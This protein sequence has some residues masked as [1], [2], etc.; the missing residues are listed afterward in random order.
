MTEPYSLDNESSDG[1]SSIE[2]SPRQ[3][4]HQAQQQQQQ[5]LLSPR[6][7]SSVGDSSD[8]EERSLG[9]WH[10]QQQQQQEVQHRAGQPTLHHHPKGGG[11]TADITLDGCVAAAA[12]GRQQGKPA[13]IAAAAAAAAAATAAAA[14]GSLPIEVDVK[15]GEECGE[16]GELR[17]ATAHFI[18]SHVMSPD[19][20]GSRRTQQQHHQQ[21]SRRQLQLPQEPSLP[22]TISMLGAEQSGSLS[23]PAT[24]PAGTAPDWDSQHS[25]TSLAAAAAAGAPQPRSV[26]PRPS[27]C[28]RHQQQGLRGPA[29]G[30]AAAGAPC[31]GGRSAAAAAVAAARAGVLDEEGDHWCSNA[32]ILAKQQAKELQQQNDALVRVLERE[33]QQHTETRQQVSHP[34]A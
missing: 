22:S 21:H 7:S 4:P 17:G 8:E 34:T 16:E 9:A 31:G 15:C 27:L 19:A 14:D 2:G 20:A 10:R 33:R 25:S 29:A 6:D 26:K 5:S 13:V 24:S 30:K 1:S 12:A 32:L 11:N 3:S 23:L 18:V 28:Q